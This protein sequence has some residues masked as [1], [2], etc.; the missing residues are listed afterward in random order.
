[1]MWRKWLPFA[2]V[3]AM[4]ARFFFSPLTTDEGGYLAVARAWFGGADLYGRVWVDRPQGLL[5]LYGVLDRVGLGSTF[6]IRLLAFLACCVAMVACGHVAWVLAGERAR[7]PTMWAVG[8]GLSLAQIEGFIANAELLSCAVGSVALAAV[9]LAVWGR[10]SPDLRLLFLAGVA[11]GAAVS[12]KQSGFD[13]LAAG[14]AAVVITAVHEK[15]GPRVFLRA[16]LAVAGGLAV[17]VGAMLAHAGLTGFHDWW[18]AVAGVRLGH[19]S[20]LAAADWHK[21]RVTAGIVAPLVA[22]PFACASVLVVRMVRPRARAVGVLVVWSAAASVAF[23]IGGLFH[24]HYWVILMFPFATIVGVTF[25]SLRS[26]TALAFVV[27]MSLVVPA[28]AT[29]RAVR[30][31]D[32]T[33]ATELNDDARL[34]VNEDV[35]AWFATDTPDRGTVWV[36]C[37]SSALYALL[38]QAPPFQY[39]WFAYFSAVQEALPSLYAWLQGPDAPSHIVAMQSARRCDP[40]GRL[41]EIVTARYEP[42]ASVDGRRILVR[43]SA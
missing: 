42:V 28:V 19:K 37:A 10:E 31:D 27:C 15:W 18:F 34:T 30:M 43:R 29:M 25:S 40:S 2:A 33:V 36:M 6:G 23:L 35:A 14:C 24:R 5:V 41:G 22:V 26:R 8:I 16:V 1:M 20:A 39:S 9:L 17:P 11:G 32:R 3:L 21:L 13:A 12:I 7:V 38:D 4:R